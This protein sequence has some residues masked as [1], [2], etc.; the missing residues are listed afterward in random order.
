MNTS[1]LLSLC[2]GTALAGVLGF[3]GLS[4]CSKAYFHRS[5]LNSLPGE[6]NPFSEDETE[7]EGKATP[8]EGEKP[9]PPK[10]TPPT[11]TKADPK[12]FHYFPYDLSLDT[13]AFMTCPQQQSGQ[14]TFKA[15][16]WF[17]RSGVRLSEYFLR[18]KQAGYSKLEELIKKSSTYQA[19]PYISLIEKNTLAGKSTWSWPFGFELHS[20]I[21]NLISTSPGRIRDIRGSIEATAKLTSPNQFA[22]LYGENHYM[23]LSYQNPKNS[24]ILTADYESPSSDF[25]GRSYKL[26][27]ERVTDSR[28]V[29]SSVEEEKWPQG[30]GQP[31]WICPEELRLEVRRHSS[32]AYKK[33]Y[34]QAILNGR[35]SPFPIRNDE[36][37]CDH[38]T[39]GGAAFE[40]VQKVLGDHYNININDKCV[41]L[42]N[43]SQACYTELIKDPNR[44]NRV[45]STSEEDFSD[46]STIQHEYCP[47]FLSIC[48]RKN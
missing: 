48:V 31:D 27:Y 7:E 32:R 22:L 17:S 2:L 16:A 39:N 1:R 43:S 10:V 36:P 41:S 47:H 37:T 24:V 45:T 12:K 33:R 44:S 8:P 19:R 29:L 35:K 42:K 15:G 30:P 46:C 26:G 14:F 34:Y 40:V 5:M 25:Y 11:P 13:L 38:S 21:K 3:T 18:Q 6:E 4:S 20:Q 28:W 23:V 9:S